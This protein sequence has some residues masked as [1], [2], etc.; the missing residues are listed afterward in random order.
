[1]TPGILLK[2][3]VFECLHDIFEFYREMR[4]H[5]PS[6]EDLLEYQLPI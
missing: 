2:Q 4:A 6:L 1:M 3:I 5:E